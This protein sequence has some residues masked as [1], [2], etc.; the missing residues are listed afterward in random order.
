MGNRVFRCALKGTSKNLLKKRYTK[1]DRLLKWYYE[2][3]GTEQTQR[4]T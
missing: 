3:I 4:K 1:I 2:P